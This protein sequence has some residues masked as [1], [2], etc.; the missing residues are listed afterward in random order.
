MDLPAGEYAGARTELINGGIFNDDGPL[1][2]YQRFWNLKQLASTPPQS[3]HLPVKCDRP[4]IACAAPGN[5]ANAQ[6]TLHIVNNGGSR[7][8]TVSGLPDTV[9]E[10]RIWVTDKQRGMQEGARIPVSGGKASFT[11]DATSYVTLITGNYSKP[12]IRATATHVANQAALRTLR[13]VFGTMSHIE[14]D[15][16]RIEAHLRDRLR[17][18]RIVHPKEGVVELGILKATTVYQEFRVLRR[19]L[20]STDL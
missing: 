12:P 2:P 1:R 9:K 19:V 20:E 18:C 14:I 5:I 13:P 15:A 7:P 17:Q 4:G 10:L 11:V 3:F 8:A 6:Y 16:S